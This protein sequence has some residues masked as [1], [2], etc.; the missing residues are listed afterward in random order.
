VPP[1]AD[2]TVAVALAVNYVTFYT[3]K[4]LQ[5]TYTT[6]MADFIHNQKAEESSLIVSIFC[7]FAQLV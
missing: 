4:Q 1:A 6:M 3:G 5:T 7:H 2:E